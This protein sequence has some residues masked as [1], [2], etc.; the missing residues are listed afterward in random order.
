MAV[1]KLVEINFTSTRTILQL[2]NKNLLE[3]K[4]HD[5]QDAMY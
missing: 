3:N 4:P 1:E 2:A 5:I